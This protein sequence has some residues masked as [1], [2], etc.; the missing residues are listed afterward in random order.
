MG[1]AEN[2]SNG[3]IQLAVSDIFA[4]IDTQIANG[5]KATIEISYMEIYKEECYD[6][7]SEERNKLDIREN[8]K[9]EAFADGLTRRHVANYD[10]VNAILK[11]VSIIR[12]TGKT[13]MN[14]QSS[15]SHAI[16][17]LYLHIENSTS[18]TTSTQDTT[19]SSIIN[20]RLHL[21]DLAGSERAKKTQATGVSFSEGVSINKGLLALGNVIVALASNDSKKNFVPYRDSKLTRLLKDSLGGNSMTVMIACISPADINF[22]ETLNTLRFAARASTIVNNAEMNRDLIFG[23]NDSTTSTEISQSVME[24]L[25][26]LRQEV[27]TL[28]NKVLILNNTP[29]NNNHNNNNNI[30]SEHEYVTLTT[31]LTFIGYLRSSLVKCIEDDIN[32]EDSDID[33]IRNSINEL[34]KYIDTNFDDSST[35]TMSSEN[36]NSIDLNFLPPIMLLVDELESIPNHI[37]SMKC[38]KEYKLNK[39]NN[40]THNEHRESI[41]STDSMP[42]VGSISNSSTGVNL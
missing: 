11:E 28:R 15:R 17:T 13:A 37:Q 14:A 26:M 10:A 7:L 23:S 5:N 20:S 2:S 18:S 29:V 22:E 42:S 34:K 33:N 4:M 36:A 39:R 16:C 8:G 40:N 41:E 1:N 35:D 24:E 19:M 25:Y 21:V 12:S 32:I 6:L 30:L 31:L 27:T 9:G 3:I 38:F